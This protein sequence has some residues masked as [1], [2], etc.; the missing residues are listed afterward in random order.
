MAD[1]H[2]LPPQ[3]T[4]VAWP[5]DGWEE[6][7]PP[8][9]AVDGG[10][11]ALLDG[12]I[13]AGTEARI[14]HTNALAIVHR[15][16]IV[17]ERYGEREM[18]PLA[19]LAGVRPG[20]LGPGDPLYSW[21]MAKSLLH[22]AVGVARADGLLD[23]RDPAP[24]PGWDDDRAAITW[25]D[26][27]AMR[28]GLQW[29]E[30]YVLADGG[31]MPDVITMLYDPDAAADMAAFAASFPLVH[32][33]GS[34]EAY[35]YSSGTSN[36]TARALQDVLGLD[37]DA[38]GAWVDE[39]ILAPLGATATYGYDGRGTWVAS[40]YVDMVARDWLR[41]GLLALRGGTWD[42]RQVVPADWIDHGRTPRSLDE[43]MYHGAHWWAR[44]NRDDG[45]FMAHGFE[46]QRLLMSPARDLV[47]FRQGK[48]AADDIDLLNE[49]LLAVVDLFPRA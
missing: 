36:I 43:T 18:G 6:A 31:P 23:H 10:L 37:G 29:V 13:G 20:P 11:D 3:P 47:L 34:P 12:L 48:T 40:S 1:L 25:D 2:P 44:P 19:E 17:A 8:A 42:G 45:L 32:P 49:R 15:G 16:R 24:V 33:P 21:S 39:R 26:L 27:L 35:C 7:G 30:E 41:V 5:T 28:P 38:M 4:G 46:G 14:G 22:L 9:A